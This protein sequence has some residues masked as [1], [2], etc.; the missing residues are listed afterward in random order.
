MVNRVRLAAIGM[1][2]IVM[3]VV[4]FER[5][6]GATW[7][8]WSGTLWIRLLLTSLLA[9]WAAFRLCRLASGLVRMAPDDPSALEHLVSGTWRNGGQPRCLIP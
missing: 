4:V 5:W 3:D 2:L 6:F 8:L 9:I 7:R 1:L